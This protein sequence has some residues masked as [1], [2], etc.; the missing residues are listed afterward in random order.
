MKRNWLLKLVIGLAALLAMGCDC[1]D[2]LEFVATQ[3]LLAGQANND[4][5]NS[6]GNAPLN[7]LAAQG[8]LVND[9]LN[10]AQIVLFD[11]ATTQG[12]TVALNT[13]GSFVYNPRFGFVGTDTFTY[14]LA[15]RAGTS[16]G[17]VSINIANRAF[18]VNNTAPAG[19]NGSFANPFNTLAAA[20]VAAGTNDTVFVFRGDGTNN[21]LAGPIALQAGQQLI[22]EGAGLNLAGINP[23]AVLAQTVVAPGAAPSITGPITLN[24][25]NTVQGFL[26][27]ASPDDAILGANIN[28]TTI[29]QNEFSNY[30]NVA[31]DIDN[32][33][34]TI[35]VT[36]NTFRPVA[37]REA[38]DFDCNNVTASLVISNNTFPDDAAVAPDDAVDVN[39]SGTSQLTITANGNTFTSPD[40][41]NGWSD[42]L[43]ISMV[44]GMATFNASGNQVAGMRSDGICFLVFGSGQGTST[45]NNNTVSD[46]GDKGIE[47]EIAQTANMTATVSGN[48][49][50]DPTT[51]I[52]D[53][54]DVD[55]FVTA[56]ATVE[57]SGNNLTGG[58]DGI[59]GEARNGTSLSL[60]I[61][62]NTIANPRDD[63]I[64]L[65]PSDTGRLTAI[66][67]RNTVTGAA[68][69]G[70]N[71]DSVDGSTMNIA[72]RD[73]T[74]N[75]QTADD[76]DITSANGST[77]CL[78]ITGNNCDQLV[79]RENGASTMN[80]ERLDAGT[81][82]PL[83][84]VNTITAGLAGLIGPPAAQNAGFCGL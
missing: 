42:G 33:T 43:N 63:G 12:G 28:G 52:A 19:G 10:A 59:E 64:D 5:F 40:G 8:V 4:S 48:T 32:P 45:L 29:S 62:N 58:G 67:T 3:S 26:L 14:T 55:T 76:I 75:G 71:G 21:N 11:A 22:G 16:V 49:V 24:S 37:G 77:A 1:D 69:Q 9:T 41:N 2:E 73:N 83:Q 54:I 36:N 44:D 39:G 27:D 46:C 82:G 53:C 84:N 81:G 65:S 60:T 51:R 72:L 68:Q 50:T 6:L 79:L 56:T 47:L 20:F 30:A 34:G 80:V 57:I 78:D 13:D 17:T 25:G 18:F 74:L 31:L 7:V 61:N 23:R 70:F 15:N 38:V 35:T 66:V